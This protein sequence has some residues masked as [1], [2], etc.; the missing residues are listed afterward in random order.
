MVQTASLDIEF[1]SL[2]AE[3]NGF[4]IN[5]CAILRRLAPQIDDEQTPRGESQL[6]PPQPGQAADSLAS[7]S[8]EKEGG[9]A[10]DR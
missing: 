9:S 3:Q 10:S 2:L 5:V 7:T 8:K 4:Q 6:D 1:R